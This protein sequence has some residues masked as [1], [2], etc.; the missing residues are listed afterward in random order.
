MAKAKLATHSWKGQGKGLH[1]PPATVW[2]TGTCLLLPLEELT[3]W[4]VSREHLEKTGIRI[5]ALILR[6]SRCES[7]EQVFLCFG[8][9]VTWLC[10][11]LHPM[12]ACGMVGR[13]YGCDE[14]QDWN[15]CF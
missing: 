13:G 5:Q 2:E 4:S 10:H 15:P 3:R 11:N 8:V 9:V 1:P 7:L 14:D 12:F 6:S